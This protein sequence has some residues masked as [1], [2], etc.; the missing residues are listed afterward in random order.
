MSGLSGQDL[1][2][3]RRR[4]I[5]RLGL[6]LQDEVS[7]RPEPEL[8]PSETGFVELLPYQ[9]VNALELLS[10]LRRLQTQET[11]WSR[12]NPVFLPFIHLISSRRTPLRSDELL[13]LMVRWQPYI[14]P[15]NPISFEDPSTTPH[16]ATS[17]PSEDTA[18]KH[19]TSSSSDS[20]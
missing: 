8:K 19:G 10:L 1:I 2:N 20:D 14:M 3:F 15:L 6:S 13:G 12:V 9:P 17:S 5:G 7:E 4:A 18:K 11:S 16:G